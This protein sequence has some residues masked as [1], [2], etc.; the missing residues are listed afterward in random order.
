MTY[1]IS[2]NSSL[3]QLSTKALYFS[4]RD[5]TKL[6]PKLPSTTMATPRGPTAASLDL[7]CVVYRGRAKLVT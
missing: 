1:T 3:A 2:P 4:L 7:P 6:P 5:A